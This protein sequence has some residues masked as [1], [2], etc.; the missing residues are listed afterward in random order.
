[1]FLVN[2]Q[3]IEQKN[4]NGCKIYYYKLWLC[5]QI[6]GIN[7]KYNINVIDINN[8]CIFCMYVYMNMKYMIN[9]IM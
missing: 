9:I 8:L 6:R 7:I 1:M 5:L 4:F 3:K 2:I